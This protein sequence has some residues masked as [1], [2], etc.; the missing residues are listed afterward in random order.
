MP[1]RRKILLFVF[2]GIALIPWFLPACD[3]DVGPDRIFVEGPITLEILEGADAAD[4]VEAQVPIRFQLVPDD[5]ETERPLLLYVTLDVP[6]EDCGRAQDVLIRSDA[7]DQVAT[8]WIFGTL[9]QDCILEARVLAGSGSL[10]GFNVIH[11]TIGPGKAVGGWLEAGMVE[12]AVDTLHASEVDFGPVD[13][14]G[15]PLLWRF[16][17]LNGPAVV[18]SEDLEDD[19]SRTLVATGIGQGELDIMT[20]FGAFV[21]AGFDVCISEEKKWIRL[22]DPEDAA[23]VLA[24]CP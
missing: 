20:P 16:Q 24:A 2:L 17:V 15:N 14:F 10:L 8:N 7:R 23:T 9:A 13:R 22:F 3:L 4:S 6:G 19:R 12:R 18:L 1:G 11:G 21:R 5:D